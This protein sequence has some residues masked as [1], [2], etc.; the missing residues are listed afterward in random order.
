MRVNLGDS[1]FACPRAMLEGV[2]AVAS[3]VRLDA[4]ILSRPVA[5]SQTHEQVPCFSHSA[6][7]CVLYV[8]LF[9]SVL[10]T[11]ARAR[12]RTHTHIRVHTYI[13]MDAVQQ[14][15]MR[16]TVTTLLRRQFNSANTDAANAQASMDLA[17]TAASLPSNTRN[18]PRSPSRRSSVGSRSAAGSS[19]AGSRNECVSVRSSVTAHGSCQGRLSGGLVKMMRAEEAGYMDD[20]C[21]ISDASRGQGVSF[22]RATKVHAGRAAQ[23]RVDTDMQYSV[24]TLQAAYWIAYSPSHGPA[25]EH[26]VTHTVMT[27]LHMRACVHACTHIYSARNAHTKGGAS[28]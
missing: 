24:H 20:S 2:S 19:V 22:L 26:T 9:V 12:A 10:C 27:V 15:P 18:T 6:C 5:L 13:D 16:D 23:V 3:G 11:H 14:V 25:C 21:S 8:C 1:P 17:R 28:N 7:V 4:Q